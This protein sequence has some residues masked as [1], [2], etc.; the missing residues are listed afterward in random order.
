MLTK[1]IQTIRSFHSKDFLALITFSRYV[2]T[3]NRL[4]RAE[5]KDAI[6]SPILMV[7]GEDLSNALAMQYQE[8]EII[9][10]SCILSTRMATENGV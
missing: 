3:R 9:I 6:T 5:L 7:V 10:T 8:Q 1:M 4:D 2:K